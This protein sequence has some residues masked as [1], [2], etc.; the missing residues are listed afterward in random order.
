MSILEKI[1]E[2]MYLDSY[3]TQRNTGRCGNMPL[4]CRIK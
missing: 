2:E 3:R 4:W 1:Y